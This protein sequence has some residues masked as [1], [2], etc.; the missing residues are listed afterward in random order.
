MMAL[1]QM[2]H[3]K[4]EEVGLYRDDGLAAVQGTNKEREAIKT[5]ITQIFAE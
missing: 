1:D 4:K 3:S 5:K 2:D